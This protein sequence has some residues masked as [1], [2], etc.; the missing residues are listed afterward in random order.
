MDHIL[1]MNSSYIISVSPLLPYTLH[2]LTPVA[3]DCGIPGLPDNGG[4]SFNATTYPSVVRYA[5]N[6]NF[7]RVG[8]NM[9]QCQLDGAWSGA[10]PVCR[11]IR[12]SL[13]WNH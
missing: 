1:F 10:V 12:K 4:N 13:A 7:Q 5:C 3:I 11:R 9:R 2:L 6:A 8:T